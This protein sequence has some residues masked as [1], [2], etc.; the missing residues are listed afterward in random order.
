MHSQGFISFAPGGD[1]GIIMVRVCAA[2][3]LRLCCRLRLRE[4]NHY[5][6]V[7]T[8]ACTSESPGVQ[9]KGL[10]RVAK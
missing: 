1:K 9:I 2:S 5:R 3:V 4:I 6:T 8:S 10:R 7:W